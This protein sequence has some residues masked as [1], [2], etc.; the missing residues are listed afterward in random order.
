[1]ENI[2][3]FENYSHVTFDR[4]EVCMKG[5]RYITTPNYTCKII[6]EDMPKIKNLLGC[7]L[8]EWALDGGNTIEI[9]EDEVWAKE[10]V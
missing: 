8:Y 10:Q 2:K 7:R 4:T 1:M 9:Y 6:E 5:V 3:T